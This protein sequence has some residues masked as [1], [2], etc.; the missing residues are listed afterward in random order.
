[1]VGK[2]RREGAARDGA[3]GNSEGV[4]RTRDRSK[5]EIVMQEERPKEVAAARLI[6]TMVLQRRMRAFA[7]VRQGPFAVRPF[8]NAAG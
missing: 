3:M 6:Y 5:R 7:A 1:M 4:T 2:G 8:T